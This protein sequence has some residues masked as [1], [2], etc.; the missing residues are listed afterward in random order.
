MAP[1]DIAAT[2]PAEPPREWRRFRFPQSLISYGSWL[3]AFTVIMH[4]DDFKQNQFPM[5]LNYNRQT[6]I[7]LNAESI[8]DRLAVHLQRLTQR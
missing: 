6:D 8:T 4:Q 7:I 2:A 1:R 3:T 5:P